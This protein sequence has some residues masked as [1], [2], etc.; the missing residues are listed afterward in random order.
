M[1]DNYHQA[2]RLWQR[3]VPHLHSGERVV[4][5]RKLTE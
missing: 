2:E 4:R 3:A 5:V 1:S